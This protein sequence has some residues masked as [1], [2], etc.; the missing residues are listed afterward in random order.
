MKYKV[1]EKVRNLCGCGC[2]KRYP[3]LTIREI[4]NNGIKTFEDLGFINFDSIA[5]IVEPD[6]EY[7]DLL[8]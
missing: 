1:G 8:V 5:K 2:V 6:K 7:E 4:R 3:T